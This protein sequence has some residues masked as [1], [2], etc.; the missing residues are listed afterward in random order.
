MSGSR[1]VLRSFRIATTDFRASPALSKVGVS[2]TTVLCHVVMRRVARVFRAVSAGLAVVVVRDVV[3]FAMSL[4]PPYEW[5][6]T[7]SH[8]S[9]VVFGTGFAPSLDP[10]FV[11]ATL[12]C[13]EHVIILLSGFSK[14]FLC[15][16]QVRQKDAY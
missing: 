5:L 12:F 9:L 10:S 7:F 4:L 16:T 15:C 3:F 1:R 13:R 2:T 6:R 8:L 11:M 14:R